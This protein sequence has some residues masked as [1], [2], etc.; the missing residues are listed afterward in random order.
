MKGTGFKQMEDLRHL[1]MLQLKLACEVRRICEKNNIQY[2]L[3]AGSCLG[4]VRHNGFIPWDDDLDMGMVRAEYD[5]FVEACKT[6]LSEEYFLQT[7]D[8]DKHFGYVFAKLRLKDTHFTEK[9]AGES[10]S[11]DGIYIDIFPYDKV[12]DDEKLRQRLGYKVRY[13]SLLLRIRCKYKPWIYH[14]GAREWLK[15]APFRFLAVFYSREKL[16]ARINAIMTKYNGTDAK[17]MTLCDNLSYN[18]TVYD[19]DNILNLEKHMFE[20]E[21]FYIPADYKRYLTATYGPD[22]MTP[23]PVDKRNSTHKIMTVDF[24]KYR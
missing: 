4:A 19:A 22:Y 13:Y 1:Q 18:K 17:R 10:G 7:N 15:Y 2:F 8:T 6:D 24:G 14:G 3:E 16:V 9:I 12:P 20:G 11:I 5:R 23:P 21:E